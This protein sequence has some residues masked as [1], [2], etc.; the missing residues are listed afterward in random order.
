MAAR[1]IRTEVLYDG[2]YA[3]V[4]SRSIRKLEVFKDQGDFEVFCELLAK[5]KR[6]HE[7]RIFHYCLMGT[8]FHIALRISL[9]E[10]F[11]RGMQKL[12]SQY[13]YKF[14]SKYRVSGPIW[15][16]R[17]RS[18]L[19]EDENYLYACG[20]Y[21][22]HNPVKAGLVEERDHW[23]YSSNRYFSHGETDGVVDGYEGEV[24][25]KLPEGVDV[26]DED[27]FEKE[28]AIGSDFFRFQLKEM[29]KGGKKGNYD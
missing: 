12:K 27:A 1:M 6:D 25:P 21:I 16:E 8:H 14:H 20:Q 24:L 19:I 9:L 28:K 4:I 15:R 3:H 5:I 13:A 10:S 17:F 18:L 2:C 23:R 11:C 22:E 7:W 29:L 26:N